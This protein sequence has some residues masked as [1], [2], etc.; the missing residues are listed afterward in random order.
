MAT[1]EDRIKKLEK[2][3][4]ELRSQSVGSPTRQTSKTL[5]QTVQVVKHGSKEHENLL[6]AGYGMTKEKAETIIKERQADPHTHPY[7]LYEKAQAL[8]GAL[9]TKPVAID[10]KPGWKRTKVQ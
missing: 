9:G 10:T 4:E 1:Q 2:E 8:L 3:L 5:E 6:E 7:E